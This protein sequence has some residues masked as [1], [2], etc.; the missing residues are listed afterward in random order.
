MTTTNESFYIIRINNYKIVDSKKY[1][2]ILYIQN[3]QPPQ[4]KKTNTIPPP[5]IEKLFLN[6]IL[7][8][9]FLAFVPL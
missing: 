6:Y 1:L 4:T 2:K 3:K 7:M 8:G 5:F 9:A